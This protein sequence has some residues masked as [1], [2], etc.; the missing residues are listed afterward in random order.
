MVEQM[1]AWHDQPFADQDN[2]FKGFATKLLV[3]GE[4]GVKVWDTLARWQKAGLYTYGGRLNK[5]EPIPQSCSN[6][7]VRASS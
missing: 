7:S 6:D 5:A 4:F 1:H 3:N 2:G